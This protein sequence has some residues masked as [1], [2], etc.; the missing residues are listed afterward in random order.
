MNS[1][2]VHTKSQPS[3]WKQYL[4]IVLNKATLAYTEL[5]IW[6]RP[7]NLQG[8]RPQL[9]YQTGILAGFALLVSILL[10][11]ADLATRSVIQL[12]LEQD[13]KAN[14]EEVVPPSLYDNNLLADTVSMPS[15]DAGLGAEQTLIYLAKKQGTV[16]AVCFKLTAPDGYAG[17]IT[18]LLGIDN[19]GEILGVRIISHVETPGLGD[20]IEISKSKWV[21]SFNGKSLD[22]VKLEQ[23]TVKKDGGVF[24]QF[25][26]ATITPRK[27]VQAIHRGMAFYRQHR[28]E[29][30]GNELM[31]YP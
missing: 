3:L 4:V 17:P 19:K 24:D 18:M 15:A 22:N 1:E 31:A 25:A 30:L 26:G 12:R 5:K 23:W 10:G 29:L 21:L 28:I 7:E 2:P 14:L 16:Q 9:R 27:V 20:K 8:L 6:L 13:L 11:I